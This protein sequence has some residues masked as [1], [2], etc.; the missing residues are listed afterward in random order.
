LARWIA[1]EL[2]V[3]DE[4]VTMH[5]DLEV[6]KIDEIA[7]S[8]LRQQ[9]STPPPPERVAKQLGVKPTTPWSNKVL[10][11]TGVRSRRHQPSPSRKSRPQPTSVVWKQDR[12]G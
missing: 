8:W 12:A 10:A 9:T 3:D 4:K 7:R 11:E 6:K 2:V 1:G 5:P